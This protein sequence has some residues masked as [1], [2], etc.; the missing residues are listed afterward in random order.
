MVDYPGWPRHPFPE[1]PVAALT[2]RRRWAGASALCHHDCREHSL[3]PGR[4]YHGGHHPSSQAGQ[5]LQFHHGLTTGML[6]LGKCL[7]EFG[8]KKESF[9]PFVPS[10]LQQSVLKW[11]DRR[12]IQIGGNSPS[13]DYSHLCF[14]PC[15]PWSYETNNPPLTP[16]PPPNTT[17]KRI[18]F[19]GII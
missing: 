17:L 19:S 5:C 2:D 8:K 4:G 3:R 16:L 6:C 13:F 15:M 10:S 1:Y 18:N 9:C 7:A 12:L 14:M 11:K